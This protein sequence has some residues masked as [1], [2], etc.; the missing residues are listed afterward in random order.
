MGKVPIILAEASRCNGNPR[1]KVVDMGELIIPASPEVKPDALRGTV[2]SSKA[3]R[4]GL[5]WLLAGALLGGL[6]LRNK[7][8]KGKE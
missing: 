3:N 8:K 5:S 1:I 2:G 6:W 4:S 7:S